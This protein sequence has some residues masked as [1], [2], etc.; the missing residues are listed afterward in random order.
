MQARVPVLSER[1]E[2]RTRPAGVFQQRVAP[3]VLVNFEADRIVDRAGTGAREALVF[4]NAHFGRVMM[5]DGI[6][7]SSSADEFV[8]HEMMS[9]VPLLAHGRVERVLILGG[10]DFGLAREVL[11]H[12]YVRRVVQI[13]SD[14]QTLELA[15]AHFAAVNATVFEDARFELNTTDGAQFLATTQEHFD[16][17]LAD[18]PEAADMQVSPLSR[19]FFR[20][21]RGCLA[22]GGLF[23]ARICSPF[24]QPLAFSMGIKRLSAVY[25]VI[26]SYLVPVPS[27]IGGPVAI[28]WASN[29]LRPDE[30]STDVLA[31]RLSNSFISTHYYT[32]EVHR[33]AFALPQFLRN[34]IS[35]A[36]RPDEEERVVRSFPQPG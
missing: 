18:L 21:A 15:R 25:P 1:I 26:A 22:P 12:R 9:H 24:L 34:T 10:A 36:T 8:Y 11:K 23:I 4:D 5:V 32:P 13:E 7:R 27:A 30:P 3:G 31:S 17:V 2:H 16:V 28:G 19:E 33:A 35:A 29:V 20:S 6:L 14:H